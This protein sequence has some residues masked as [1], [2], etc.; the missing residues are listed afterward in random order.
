MKIEKL[1]ELKANFENEV[2]IPLYDA[3][4]DCFWEYDEAYYIYDDESAI[5]LDDAW[6]EKAIETV[7]TLCLNRR[8]KRENLEKKH[9]RKFIE[10]SNWRCTHTSKS[11]FSSDYTAIK[12]FINEDVIKLHLCENPLIAWNPLRLINHPNE[13]C[14]IIFTPSKRLLEQYPFIKKAYSG[15]TRIISHYYI[16]IEE[17]KNYRSGDITIEPQDIVELNYRFYHPYVWW[18]IQSNNFTSLQNN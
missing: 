2:G 6:L 4:A 17:F 1:N 11:R 16:S 13:D 14:V 7:K 10:L 18:L 3:F 12:S 9:I 5:M 8:T 15:S